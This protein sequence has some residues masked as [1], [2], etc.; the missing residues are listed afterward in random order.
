[1]AV[2]WGTVAILVLFRS[3]D[4]ECVI[5][6]KIRTMVFVNSFGCSRILKVF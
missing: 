5:E 1:M 4:F 3:R 2:S 6:D